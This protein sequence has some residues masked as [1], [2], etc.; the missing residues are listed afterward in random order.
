MDTDYCLRAAALGFK[1]ILNPK[2]T[3]L[4]SIGKRQKYQSL[5][6]HYSPVGTVQRVAR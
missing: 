2:V 3:F 4:H 5:E 1:L 6:E